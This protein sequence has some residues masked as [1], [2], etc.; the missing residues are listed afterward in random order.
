MSGRGIWP[1]RWPLGL[2]LALGFALLVS[3]ALG[4]G[5][6]L[7]LRQAEQQQIAERTAGLIIQA[8]A[9]ANLVAE[10]QARGDQ[11]ELQLALYRFLQQTG[12]RPVVTDL[13]A[14]VVADSWTD[15]DL[16]GRRLTQP[17]LVR[18]LAGGQEFGQ[19]WLGGEN[20][21]MYVAVPVYRDRL[22]TGAVMLSADLNFIDR[23]L[24]ELRQQLLLVSVAAGLVAILLGAGLARY[25]ALPLERLG[26]A[27]GELARG[28]LET[29]VEPAGSREVTHLGQSFNRMAQELGR[30]DRQRRAFVAD[31]SHELRTPVAS[32]RA[33]AEALHADRTG[34]VERY[35]EYLGDII[36]ECDRAA[37]LT[38]RLLELARL[39]LRQEAR[40]TGRTAD[41]QETAAEVVHALRPLAQER[42]VGLT[43]QPAGALLLPLDPRLVETVLG[44]LVENALKYTPPGGEV[45]VELTAVGTEVR[46]AVRD[47]GPGIA[48]E[49]LPHIFARFYRVDRARSRATGGAGLGLA[50]AAEAAAHL[51]GRIEVDSRPGAGSCF[52]LVL[53]RPG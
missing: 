48:A 1:G 51:G 13:D 42:G 20:R 11:A 33:L 47:N 17:E 7:L 14:T 35:K 31:A 26:R 46:L 29:R 43:L 49:H 16:L 50:I 18:A 39:D 6:A 24:A 22:I 45:Q 27:A 2:Q 8:N 3:L 52:T 9:A 30:L 12:V 4:G 44:N 41:L 53:K 25:L 21:V 37:R 10:L 23:G 34:N 38:D 5:G 40:R 15:S 36:H 19:R 32:V 28:R